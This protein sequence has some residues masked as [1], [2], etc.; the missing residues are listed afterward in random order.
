MGKDCPRDIHLG[1]SKRFDLHGNQ[2]L[3]DKINDPRRFHPKPV[4][5]FFDSVM[6]DQKKK[7]KTD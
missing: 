5:K 2:S 7:P 1:A 3:R 6:N 4:Q